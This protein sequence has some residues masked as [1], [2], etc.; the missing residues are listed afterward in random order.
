MR[1]KGG[2]AL[3]CLFGPK[4]EPIDPVSLKSSTEELRERVDSLTDDEAL[5]YKWLREYYSERWIA[6]TLFISR[7]RQR[8]LTKSLCRK[9]GVSNTRAMRRIYGQLDIPKREPVSTG[10]I[11]GYVEK[12]TEKEIQTLLKKDKDP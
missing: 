3:F 5:I 11:D 2:S 10:E 6:E 9:L 1:Q 8:E 12:R 7:A 4:S